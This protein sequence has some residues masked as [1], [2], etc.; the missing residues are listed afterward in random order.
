MKKLG[1]ALVVL[2]AMAATPVSAATCE[3]TAARKAEIANW[4]ALFADYEAKYNALAKAIAR[5]GSAPTDYISPNVSPTIAQGPTIRDS[6][7]GKEILRKD[8]YF[9]YDEVAK[10]RQAC[11]DLNCD[12]YTLPSTHTSAQAAL[13]AFKAAAKALPLFYGPSGMMLT[14]PGYSYTGRFMGNNDADALRQELVP[15]T[16]DGATDR[17]TTTTEAPTTPSTP[18]TPPTTSTGT[19]S[20]EYVTS[21]LKQIQD[22]A[23]E[24]ALLKQQLAAARAGSQSTQTSYSAPSGAATASY[25]GSSG[26][27]PVFTRPLSR[28][29]TGF[30]VSTLQQFL[31]KDA[32]VYPEGLVTAYFGPATERAVQRWQENKG[33]VSIGG[34]GSGTVGPKTQAAISAACQ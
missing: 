29:A 32:G 23:A 8:L 4:L 15:K 33:V 11:R 17:P 26:S 13:N 20:L 22:L 30:D 21:L 28:G 14:G 27:C 1:I 34:A 25:A 3:P 16:C 12:S 9:G 6:L 5:G 2:V 31:A 10:A 19:Y 24:N 18:A 7:D